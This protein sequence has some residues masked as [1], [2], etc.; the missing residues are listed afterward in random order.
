MMKPRSIKQIL[1]ESRIGDFKN[2]LSNI[3]D[4]QEIKKLIVRDT[5]FNHKNLVWIGKILR[6]D[7]EIDQDELFKN[8]DLFNKIGRGDLYKF[9]TYFEFLDFLNKKSKEVDSSKSAQLK[10]D[11]CFLDDSKRWQ[12]VAPQTHSS[13]KHFGG[14]T[15]WCISVSKDSYWNDYFYQN[16][17]VII[18]DRKKRQGDPLFKVA[19]VGAAEGVDLNMYRRNKTEKISELQRHISFW[20]SNDHKLKNYESSVFLNQLPDDLLDTIADYF[21]RDEVASRQY[22][23]YYQLAYEK[24]DKGRGRGLLL[25]ELY[26]STASVL[27]ISETDDTPDKDEFDTAMSLMFRSEIEDGN[28]DEFLRQLWT[29]C[30]NN[31]GVDDDDFYPQISTID[32][33]NLISDTQYDVDTYL[34]FARKALTSKD[35][36]T[37]DNII[38]NSLRRT[39]DNVDPYDTLI[40][41]SDMLKGTTYN[42]I[43]LSSLRMYNNKYNPSYSQGQRSLPNWQFAG[44]IN[45]FVPKNIEDVIKVLSLNP[46]AKDMIDW[47]QKYRKDL[48]ESTKKKFKYRDFFR[49]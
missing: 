1:N 15:D 42:D 31:Q 6:D 32:L 2:L 48:Y 12:V 8:L 14:G 28:W 4:E 41:H 21:E 16:T 18:K 25:R 7:P 5:S 22:E 3:F 17:I 11:T 40:R 10:R 44:I 47:I 38:K 13:S 20:N 37:M 24:F 23:R 46:R 33:K 45:Q 29:A 39:Y 34:E 9:R 26:E 49:F 36:Q 27:S 30:M 35:I 43:L 19:L